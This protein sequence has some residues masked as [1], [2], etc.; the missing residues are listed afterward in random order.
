VKIETFLKG[1][2]MKIQFQTSQLSRP[3]RESLM[4]VLDVI[5]SENENEIEVTPVEFP[6][7]LKVKLDDDIELLLG[8]DVDKQSYAG[9]TIPESEPEPEKSGSQNL[10]SN[11]VGSQTPESKKDTVDLPKPESTPE[12]AVMSEIGQRVQA[13]A[14]ALVKLSK[15]LNSYHRSEVWSRFTEIYVKELME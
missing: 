6:I 5:Q 10:T 4:S 3:Q 15:P 7:K 12:L 2:T 14:Q 9:L 11:S 1:D 13:L 8:W